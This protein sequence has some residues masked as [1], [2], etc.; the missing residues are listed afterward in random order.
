MWEDFAVTTPGHAAFSL[1]GNLQN[2]GP[3]WHAKATG[4]FDGDNK[5][6]IILWQNDNS[7]AAIWLMDGLQVKAGY[8]VA[9]SAANGPSW[10]AIAARD[11]DGDDRADI[12]WQNDSGAVA[13]WEDFVPG[14][15][16]GTTAS[17]ADQFNVVPDVNPTGNLYW[18]VL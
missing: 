15:G 7:Q 5:D 8:D 2:N 9:G 1:Q 10:H 18:H 3:T 11:M 6:D 14:P 4:D 16:S 12:L 17:F 13:V